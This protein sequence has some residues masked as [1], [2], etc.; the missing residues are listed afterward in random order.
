ML[1]V[2]YI[3]S[4]RYYSLLSMGFGLP[5][6]NQRAYDF[7]PIYGTRWI[8][9][10]FAIPT[11]IFMLLGWVPGGTVGLTGMPRLTWSSGIYTLCSIT[12]I[13]WTLGIGQHDKPWAFRKLQGCDYVPHHKLHIS[14]RIFK[15]STRLSWK[16]NV[17]PSHFKIRCSKIIW[18]VFGCHMEIFPGGAN[19]N[20]ATASSYCRLLL[21]FSADLLSLFE[22]YIFRHKI[23][24]VSSGF[25]KQVMS[26]CR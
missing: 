6:Q 8:G 13:P 12:S 20:S 23:R 7:R 5:Y 25:V 24:R 17:A 15:V 18:V 1:W 4:P 11:L 22:A 21:G 2:W 26:Y 19:E 14:C 9:W 3:A 16:E 10:T